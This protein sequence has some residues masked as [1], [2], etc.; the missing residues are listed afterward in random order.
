MT[1]AQ[2]KS[3][4]HSPPVGQRLITWIGVHI[5]RTDFLINFRID[6]STSYL[7]STMNYYRMKYSNCRFLVASDDKIYAQKYLSNLTDVFILPS[8][9]TPGS[10]LAMLTLS[11]HSLITAG[12]FGWWSAW[13]TGGDVVHD[14]NFPPRFINCI[15][16]H[17]FPPWFLFPHN[18]SSLRNNQV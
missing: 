10:D 14:L 17:Y 8:S 15:R 18:S 7:W 5:R 12:S 2:L 1:F 16:E 4:F 13:L 11:D 9:L 6:T 3:V